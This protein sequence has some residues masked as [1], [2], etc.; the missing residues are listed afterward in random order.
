MIGQ[1]KVSVTDPEVITDLYNR[2]S[3]LVV[4]QKSNRDMTD[5]YFHISF[6]LQDDTEIKWD[7]H[8]PS[9]WYNNKQTYEV[10]D[11]GDLWP[12]VRELLDMI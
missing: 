10:N 1:P 2:L 8:G 6:V 5:A 4:V 11:E 7:F 3:R 12:K 9:L